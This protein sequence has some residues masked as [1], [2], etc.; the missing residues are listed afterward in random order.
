VDN[1]IIYKNKGETFKC[2][3]DIDGASID[4]I[5]VRLCL[6]FGDNKNMFFYGNI[7]EKGNCDVHIPRLSELED[8]SGKMVIEAIVDSTYFR[9]Y[10]CHVE[11]KNSVNV[12]MKQM[13][14]TFFQDRG[15]T[16]EAKIQL[17]GLERDTPAAEK[18]QIVQEDNK[19]EEKEIKKP[20]SGYKWGYKEEDKP[21][22]KPEIKE[23]ATLT[24]EDATN[25]YT[26]AKHNGYVSPKREKKVVEAHDEAHDESHDKSQG[27]RKFEDF[28]TSNNLK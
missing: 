8:K 15:P 24:K 12:K 23:E 14:G 26:R 2:N 19:G 10:E 4:D 6:E 25:P 18:S 11:L 20:S 22:S 21:K 27:F 13:E 17:S 1:N 5:A 3:F 16:K 28:L 7:D 9:L